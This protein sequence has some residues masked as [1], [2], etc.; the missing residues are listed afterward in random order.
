MFGFRGF[1]KFSGRE[2]NES[3]P[4]SRNAVTLVS[5]EDIYAQRLDHD[6]VLL[7]RKG[8]EI[9]ADDLPRLIRNGASPTQFRLEYDETQAYTRETELPAFTRNTASPASDPISDALRAEKLI[10][11]KRSRQSVV[12]L[13]PD[14]KSL[15]RLI[16]CLFVCGFSLPEI[17]PVRMA[18]QLDWAIHKY[19]P[20]ILVV[21]YEG[22]QLLR[23]FDCA[24]AP[25]Q[26]IMTVSPDHEL[27]EE[28][29]LEKNIR[30]LQK[31]VNRFDL[32]ALLNAG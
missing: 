19:S 18:S 31:P 2:M 13:E 17:H 12:I 26:L 3:S 24:H 7:L 4:K 8:S 25:S 22:L 6:P 1:G 21:D 23:N 20:Q 29:Y 9:T 11:K 10:R 15:K 16:D 28:L 5:R 32:N 30:I 27:P 14:Q